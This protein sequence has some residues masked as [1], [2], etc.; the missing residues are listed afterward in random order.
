MVFKES[1]YRKHRE[2]SFPPPTGF[3][4]FSRIE[5]TEEQLFNYETTTFIRILRVN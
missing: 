2:D 4:I 3:S 5:N 1:H